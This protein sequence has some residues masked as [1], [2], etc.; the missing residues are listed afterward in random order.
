MSPVTLEEGT[1]RKGPQLSIP[2]DCL[3]KTQ[4]SAKVKT[5]V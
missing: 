1:P 2:G 3:P 5:D 4:V